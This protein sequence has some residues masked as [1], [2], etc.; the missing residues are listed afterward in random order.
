MSNTEC[1]AADVTI[2]DS[3]KGAAGVSPIATGG[4]GFTFERRVAANF[5]AHLL[6]G[7]G[8]PELRGDWHVVSVAFQQAPEHPVDDLVIHAAHSDDQQALLTLALGVRRS[9]NLV[10]SDESALKLVR[11][12]VHA[13]IENPQDEREYRLGLVVAGIQPHAKELATLASHAAHQKDAPGFFKLIRTPRKFDAGVQRRLEHLEQ[14]VKLSLSDL[15]KASINVRSAQ[16]HTWQLLQR[17]SVSMPRFA[18]S[19][20]MDWPLVANSLIPIAR[21]NALEGALSL[22][23]RLFTLAG[24]FA[25][26]A[27]HVDLRLLRRA[28]YDVLDLTVRHHRN[29]WMILDHLHQNSLALVREEISQ[30]KGDRHWRLDRSTEV[31]TLISAAAEA[32]TVVVYG[33]SGTGKS[34]LVVHGLSRGV[35]ANQ[36]R[37]QLLCLNLRHVH[38]LTIDFEHGLGCP[39]SE[40]LNELAAP[41]R[42]L[43]IDGADAVVEDKLDAFRYLVRAAKASDVK[44]IATT[45]IEAKQVVQDE[46]IDGMGSLVAEHLVST[47]S[48]TAIGDIVDIFPELRRLNAND[49]S[50]TLLRRLVVV[51]LLVRSGISGIPLTDADAMFTVWSGLVCRHGMPEEGA[52]DKR[53]LVLLQLASLQ[54]RGIDGAERLDTLGGLDSDALHGLCRDGLIRKSSDDPFA[55]GPEFA[56]DEIRRYATARLF[57]QGRIPASKIQDYG[58][59]RW[60]LAAARLACQ[61][62]L[63]EQDNSS[64]PMRGRLRRLQ[65]SFDV[66]ADAGHGVRWADMPGEALLLLENPGPVLQDAWPDLCGDNVQ[67]LRRLARLVDQRLFDS[68]GNVDIAPVE[69][70]VALLIEEQ[71]PWRLGK[72][73]Q[74]L[75][76]NWLRG[77]IVADTAAGHPLRIQLRQRFVDVCTA[78]YHRL[79][80]EQEARAAALAARTPE[81]IEHDKQREERNRKFIGAIGRRGS[82]PQRPEIPSEITSS[83]FL[84]LLALLGPDLG[85]EGETILRTIAQD[86]SWRLAPALEELFTGQA[87]ATYGQ[88]LLAQLTEAYYLDD[89]ADGHEIYEDGVRNHDSR[90]KR[91]HALSAWDRGPFMWLFRTDFLGGVAVL[92]RLLNHA[93]RIRVQKLVG[94]HQS[95]PPDRQDDAG[96]HKV[97]L[98]IT[99]ER[100]LYL[101]DEQVW[102][103]YRG[104]G[105]GPFPCFS[106]LQALERACDQWIKIGISIKTIVSILLKEC[107]SLSMVSL[108]VGL[109]VRHLEDAGPLLDPYLAEPIIWDYEF[110]RVVAE[111]SG[112]AANSDELLA[113]DRRMWS[114]REAARHMVLRSDPERHLALQ[115]ISHKLIANARRQIRSAEHQEIMGAEAAG[116]LDPKLVQVRAWASNLDRSAYEAEVI[117]DGLQITVVPPEDVAEALQNSSEDLERG[118]MISELWTRYSINLDQARTK[119]IGGDMLTADISTARQLLANPPSVSDQRPRDIPAMVAAS[120]IEG[121]F[122][123]GIRLNDEDLFFAADTLIRVGRGEAGVSPYEMELTVFEDG[124]ERSAARAIS[125]LLLPAAA[126]L[127]DAIDKSSGRTEKHR[128]LASRLGQALRFMIG[129]PVESTISEQIVNSGIGLAQSIAN[130]VRLHLARGLD[131]LWQVP[132]VEKGCCH[133]DVGLRLA[134]ETMRDCILGSWNPETRKRH[135]IVL[136]KQVDETLA[137]TGGKSILAGRLNGAIRALAPAATSDICI[138]SRAHALLLVVLDAQQRSLLSSEYS[139]MSDKDSHI[140]A[141][142]RA[143]LTLAEHGNDAIIYDHIDAYAD[144]P[145]LLGALLRAL[146][147]AAEETQVRA[148]TAKRMW[149]GVVRHVLVLKESRHALFQHDFEGD[150]TVAALIP[151]SAHE[152]EYLYREIQDKPIVWW[153]PFSL[154]SEINTWLTS[155]AGRATCVDQL[156][157]FIAGL[158]PEQQVQTGLP[159]LAKL[160]LADPA[161]IAHQTWHL[162]DWL[163]EM[164]SITA[165][166]E[167]VLRVWQDVV[168]A[169]VV[170]GVTR[171]APYSE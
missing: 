24:E 99:G 77:H 3:K 137:N 126:S 69:P 43:I 147:A 156:I 32:D 66:L 72:H 82:Q 2:P 58:A 86:A 65:E 50:R 39:L 161:R 64:N 136:E 17:L 70:I 5:L 11:Q 62:I 31:S 90:S 51:D 1:N 79:I 167:E 98:H 149:P 59:P 63:A 109:L 9:L 120:A 108:V 118:E 127:R 105:V 6:I 92:N 78:S 145:A 128:D 155:A 29:G 83:V 123:R 111:H 57:L 48:D 121:H 141:S 116:E 20:E 38:R 115:E 37:I 93:T 142:A 158:A 16:Q 87:L 132:C 55:I 27:A 75:L 84:E 134:I 169:L 104:S 122:L 25:P 95:I 168:D 129:R 154:Q 130:E 153:E 162:S 165:G 42:M 113:K 96:L 4:G 71:I 135:M 159:W 34:S 46:L 35:E 74:G 21:G 41:Q 14:L 114:L 19:D 151:N 146:S 100:R 88:G 119:Q 97:E 143:L 170:E 150:G 28:V 54:L 124:A 102:L 53:E 80:K 125:L 139:R 36:D 47:L 33:E 7:D 76:R 152:T 85:S 73:A 40:L 101:G 117:P 67:G 10:Q 133:H 148:A 12:F 106:A 160:I 68:Q 60:A 138:S 131:H 91:T 89:E 49:R 94:L 144:S 56:H 112:L 81:E 171:L 8:I 44:I 164:H 163:I 110:V 23:D 166:N 22:R 52:P 157:C 103:W 45:S 13:V 26:A 107:E 15:G 30:N 61:V 18:L 140:L